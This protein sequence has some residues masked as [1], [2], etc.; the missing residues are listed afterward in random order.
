MNFKDRFGVA[1][2]LE[3]IGMT[4]TC[5]P[6][7]SPRGIK[8]PYAAAGLAVGDWYETR[9]IDPATDAELPA[10][11]VGELAVRPKVPWIISTGY[12]N[13]PEQTAETWRNLW[14][15]TGDAVKRD[16]AGW[17]Y[18]MDRLK[19]SIRRRG[20]NISSYEIELQILAHPAVADVAAIAVR[21][22][23]TVNDDEIKVFIVLETGHRLDLAQLI[24]WC[25]QRLPHFAVPRYAEIVDAFPMTPSGKVQKA[26][27]REKGLGVETWD[28]VAA[29]VMLQREV[30][31]AEKK[32]APVAK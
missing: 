6:V 1:E 24:Q 32:R 29:G 15:H 3:I 9:V 18:F 16:A 14:F 4:E 7:M 12:E 5:W 21:P 20:E 28:R 13:M 17:F 11:E 27:L 8:P 23:P 22:D 19:D 25:D 26:R 2:V 31:Q 10:G 30:A